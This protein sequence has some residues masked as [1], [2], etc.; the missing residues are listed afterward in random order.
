MSGSGAFRCEEARGAALRRKASKYPKIL[1]GTS[2]VVFWFD[3]V[4][5]ADSADVQSFG[6]GQT[7][8]C[9]FSGVNALVTIDHFVAEQR[10]II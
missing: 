10:C 4:N 6:E 8:E 1:A 9:W 3:R 5:P 7:Q 2:Q